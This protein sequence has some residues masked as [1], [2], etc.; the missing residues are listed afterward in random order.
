MP[1]M[2]DCGSQSPWSPPISP[3]VPLLPLRYPSTDLSHLPFM[4][5]CSQH[6]V[7]ACLTSGTLIL[8]LSLAEYISRFDLPTLVPPPYPS[9]LLSPQAASPTF[10]FPINPGYGAWKWLDP[11]IVVVWEWPEVIENEIVTVWNFLRDTGRV[12]SPWLSSF[13]WIFMMNHL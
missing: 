12:T 11:I 10:D 5:L 6:P 4:P 8:P 3:R 9:Q 7:L 1:E 13:F 2:E